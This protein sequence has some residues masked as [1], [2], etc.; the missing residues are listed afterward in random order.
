MAALPRNAA[1][2]GTLSSQGSIWIQRRWRIYFAGAAIWLTPKKGRD[3]L[4]MLAHPSFA[5]A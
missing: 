1:S 4:L 3:W 2:L 5:G